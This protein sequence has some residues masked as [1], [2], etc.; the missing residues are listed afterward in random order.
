MGYVNSTLSVQVAS[1]YSYRFGA[2][3]SSG[4]YMTYHYIY[5]ISFNLFPVKVKYNESNIILALFI[6]KIT[7]M[8]PSGFDPFQIPIGY[9]SPEKHNRSTSLLPLVASTAI[10]MVMTACIAFCFRR[11]RRNAL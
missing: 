7:Y 2:E 5:P 4:P 6:P 11:W 1:L 8:S 10:A 3:L 9:Y